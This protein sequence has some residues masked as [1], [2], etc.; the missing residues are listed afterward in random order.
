MQEIRCS[1]PKCNKVVGKLEFG[2]A[3]FKCK[4]CGTYTTA[5]ILPTQVAPEQNI[6]QA[7]QWPERANAFVGN[8][9]RG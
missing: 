8:Y 6:Q 1:G 3:E 4:H 7:T 5:E 9:G 2:K